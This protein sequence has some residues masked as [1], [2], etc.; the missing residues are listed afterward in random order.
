MKKYIICILSAIFCTTMFAQS[1]ILEQEV[2]E[3]IKKQARHVVD[4]FTTHLEY[5][6]ETSKSDSI[7]DYHID[8]AL[9]LFIGK[10]NAT[11]DKDGDTI[12]APIIEVSSVNRPNEKV[13]Y[14]IKPYLKRMKK[15]QY[16][17][18][19]LKTSSSYCVSEL[20]PTGQDCEYEAVLSVKQL[21]IGMRGEVTVYIDT[22]TKNF[23]VHI[24]CIKGSNVVRWQ[25][26][27]GNVLVYQTERGDTMNH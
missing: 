23:H 7:K 9:D 4:A 3:S 27:L 10:G 2:N 15:L 8:A 17:K 22:T 5:I 19:I 12:P 11:I 20:Q 14:L 18:V 25:I 21:F 13:P 1:S 16:T 26:L 24:K 6:A